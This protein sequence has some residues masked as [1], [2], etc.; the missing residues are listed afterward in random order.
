MTDLNNARGLERFSLVIFDWAGTMVDFG[1]MAPVAALLEAFARHGVALDETI[2]RADMGKA[3]ADHV[4]ALL[5]YPQVAAAWSSATATTM[6]RRPIRSPM[7][8]SIG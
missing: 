7:T 3:K 4:R 5:A 8:P 2:A 1:C 6:R